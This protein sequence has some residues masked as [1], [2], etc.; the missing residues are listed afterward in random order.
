[1]PCPYAF[2]ARRKSNCEVASL[3][4]SSHY[5][6]SISPSSRHRLPFFHF[7][8]LITFFYLPAQLSENYSAPR[9]YLWA[10]SNSNVVDFT[11]CGHLFDVNNWTFSIGKSLLIMEKNCQAQLYINIHLLQCCKWPLASRVQRGLHC[12]QTNAYSAEL[13][14]LPTEFPCFFCKSFWTLQGY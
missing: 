6:F 13:D 3:G 5:P 10:F 8:K 2:S 14:K 4:F 12:A 1:M 9:D 7:G 11:T